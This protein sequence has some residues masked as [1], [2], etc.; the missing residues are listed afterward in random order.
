[1]ENN[2]H[3][4]TTEN[5]KQRL[6]KRIAQVVS[7]CILAIFLGVV[8]PTISSAPAPLSPLLDSSHGAVPTSALLPHPSLAWIPVV[9]ALILLVP[10]LFGIYDTVRIYLAL[11]DS[12]EHDQM[13]P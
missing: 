9:I 2:E 4:I 7:G 12:Q 5:L 13:F 3:Q 6:I 8:V 10:I 1:M 11:R